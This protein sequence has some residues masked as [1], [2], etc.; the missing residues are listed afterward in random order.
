MVSVYRQYRITDVVSGQSWLDWGTSE[1]DV[2][3]RACRHRH[4]GCDMLVRRENGRYHYL[5]GE[6]EYVA[7][8]ALT[9]KEVISM[10]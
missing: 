4:A 8:F 1:R 2:L 9:L 10:F 7:A 6:H 3:R 5:C